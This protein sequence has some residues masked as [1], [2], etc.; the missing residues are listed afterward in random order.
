LENIMTVDPSFLGTMQFPILLAR[1]MEERD[2][3]SPQVPVV[4][5]QFAKQFFPNQSPV[6]K[7]IG[8]GDVKSRR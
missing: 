4:S 8:F 2:M 3:Q 1:G 6:G 5:E 7:R